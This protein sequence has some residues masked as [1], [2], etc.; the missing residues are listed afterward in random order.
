MHAPRKQLAGV[1][2]ASLAVSGLILN[3]GCDSKSGEADKA[4]K[5]GIDAS[6][7]AVANGGDGLAE[8]E[9]AAGI[10]E[11]SPATR[12][13]AKALLAQAELDA[14]NRILRQKFD[15]TGAVNVDANEVKI[16]GLVGEITHTS[17]QIAAGN[18]LVAG[19]QKRDPKAERDA[20]QAKIEEAKGGAGKDAWFK[21]DKEPSTIPT[22]EAA[23]AKVAQLQ[24]E[25]SKNESQLKDLTDQRNAALQ[26]A[27][28]LT[29]DS[30][31]LRGTDAVKMYKDGAAAR[32]NAG[33][34]AVQIDNTNAI[35]DP[36]RADL[37]V[38]EGQQKA[39]ETALAGFEA[40]IKQIDDSWAE[41]QKQA[42]AQNT[43][44]KALLSGGEGSV[45]T[46]GTEMMALVD[47]TK[48]LRAEA[49]DKLNNA[50][51]HFEEAAKAAEEI[52]QLVSA[53]NSG[54]DQSVAKALKTLQEILNPASYK[55]QAANAH[56]QLANLHASAA[57]S[58]AARGK[59]VASL[60]SA[61]SPGGMSVP[62][63]LDDS[64]IDS[65][66]KSER[67]LAET[68]FKTAED[69]YL[70]AQDATSANDD[71][72]VASYIGRMTV[73]YGWSQLDAGA[74]NTEAAATH[75]KSARDARDQAKNLAAS[76][77]VLPEDLELQQAKAPTAPTTEP[78]AAPT[79][80]PEPAAP[81]TP[82]APAT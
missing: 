14:A 32:K 76:F 1:L 59:M 33:E 47:A 2:F 15:Q 5:A 12:A 64:S 43:T 67:G 8:L 21:Q 69:M 55:L 39:I 80:Q 62:S 30:E 24:G 65:E 51:T 50:A 23:K 40:Q 22:L 10:Q 28:K 31:G 48:K 36:L 34:L 53:A 42:D 35:L 52:K 79:T 57:S 13:H 58:L 19:Y 70:A 81:T 49:V 25:I 7:A 60:K 26:Q 66:L 56:L 9:K 46:K 75:L 78:A 29:Q 68:S 77:P 16:A 18:V 41:V 63:G 44:A 11:A 3:T 45:T 4:I 6:A 20:V 54:R 37:K 71:I 38:A 74:G 61:L 17:Q 72:R 73:L 82:P 27:D